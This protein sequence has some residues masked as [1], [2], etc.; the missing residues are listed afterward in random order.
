MAAIAAAG[1]SATEGTPVKEEK[2][3]NV[4]KP[5]TTEMPEIARTLSTALVTERE[6]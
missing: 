1:R 6:S 5:Y 4:E 2:S 3:T